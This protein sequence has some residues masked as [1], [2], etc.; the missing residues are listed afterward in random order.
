M[1][2][3][4][5][6]PALS[7]RSCKLWFWEH[8]GP[9]PP[10]Q[11][12]CGSVPASVSRFLVLKPRLSSRQP[13]GT[14]PKGSQVPPRELVGQTVPDSF[15]YK[16]FCV[17]MPQGAWLYPSSPTIAAFYW[18]ERRAWLHTSCLHSLTIFLSRKIS[19]N[20]S[21]Q[22]YFEMFGYKKKAVPCRRQVF[23]LSPMG[24]CNFHYV[25]TTQT[26]LQ[27]WEC[28]ANR[29][30]KERQFIDITE[31]SEVSLPM[32][33]ILHGTLKI[34][35]LLQFK[36]FAERSEEKLNAQNSRRVMRCHGICFSSV[37][38]EI[39]LPANTFKHFF[40]F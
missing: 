18:A 40:V 22:M 24:C 16:L 25:E 5:G 19:V 15:W 8:K 39:N 34:L 3:G 7:F 4:D 21:L 9:S 32:H 33:S 29:T 13:L 10:T 38:G 6:N 26:T 1:L 17:R 28:S 2:W 35:D 36:L 23:S 37:S 20:P 14:F 11:Q 12:G 31:V 30:F 27:G